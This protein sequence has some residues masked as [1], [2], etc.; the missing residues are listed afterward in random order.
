MDTVSGF[1]NIL[2]NRMQT[3]NQSLQHMGQMLNS[4]SYKSVLSRG[5]AIVRDA[6]NNI[7]SSVDGGTPKSIEFKDGLL[8]L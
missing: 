5:Y 8:K 6:D 4:L 2:Q 7:I 3:L 1:S